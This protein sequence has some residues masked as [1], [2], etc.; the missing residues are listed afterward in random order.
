MKKIIKRKLH[1]STYSRDF[2]DYI[3]HE[4]YS[5]DQHNA[6]FEFTMEQLATDTVVALFY[7]Q[8]T[9]RYA[10]IKGTVED[11]KV[12]IEFDTSLITTNETVCG[13]IYFEKVEQS[14]DVCRFCFNVKVSEIDKLK[15]APVIE[16]ETR[17]LIPLSEIVTKAELEELFKTIERNGGTYNDTEIRSSITSIEERVQT[18][19]TKPD[20][21]TV[22]DDSEL[23]RRVS[24]LETKEDKDTVYNDEEIKR[25]LSNLEGKTD[26]FISG[27]SVNKE[28][29]N[30]TLTYNYVDGQ[31]KN[32]SFTDSDTVNIAYDDSALKTRLN[33]L[34]NRPQID[35]S[36][37]AKK[38]DIPQ[39]YNDSE[40]SRRVS[41]LE[42]K[43]DKDTVYN[44]EE[45]KRRLSNLEGK[46][47]NFISGVS[48]NKEG[49]NVTL[50]YNYVDGQAKNVSFT[51]S[52]TINIAYDDSALK[53]R[54]TNLE[55]RPQIDVSEFAK[56]TDI[57][58][59]YNDSELSRRVSAL[60]TKEDKDT[61]Y[62]DEEI[63]RRLSNLEGKTDNFISGVSVNKEGNNVTLTYNYVDG[64]TKNVSFTDSDTINIAY[65]DSALKT[66]LTNLEE[67]P[68]IDVSEF[69]KK[70]EVPTAESV[71][72]LTQKFGEHDNKIQILEAKVG[73][74]IHGTGMPNG[75]VEAPIGTTYIDTAKTN[76][77]LKW[78]KT[79][80]GGN[81][82]WKVVEGDTGWVLCWQED[83]GN[84]KNRMYFRRIN[85]VVHV[86]FEPKISDNVNAHEYNLI[87]DIG[88]SDIFGKLSIQ[89]FQSVDNIVQTIFKRTIDIPGATY[90]AEN[91]E[92]SQGCGAV[93]LHY[94]YNND[95]KRELELHIVTSQFSSDENHVNPFSYL[96][97]DEWPTTLP[98]VS[99]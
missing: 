75:V 42:T 15:N 66:R 51:D 27:V 5:H 36:E 45:I 90:S 47:D 31:A 23:N 92:A 41:A 80:D 28:G 4:F 71:M 24:A 81:E 44:D 49:N 62:N 73:Y 39:A 18:L 91:S 98:T 8:K 12:T 26:N 14:A 48:V 97:E 29:N 69:A 56:K 87:L 17:R 32:V 35:V 55:E 89:G 10:E 74:E 99:E 11:N 79:T 94:V 52:D 16:K 40:L 22:Y 7:F 95:S 38:T 67:R 50:T 61:V 84:N 34:E 13:Y 2:I 85:D 30:V 57:P 93:C 59:A 88:G 46:T 82:G 1:I 83:N 54:L 63:K 68:Q 96:T 9:K 58:Q 43:E 19:E 37:F 6:F 60:E 25:R 21:N 70:S 86:K 72:D 65:D 53:A 20:N 64:Q 77:A 3:N 78:I 76:G 33:D